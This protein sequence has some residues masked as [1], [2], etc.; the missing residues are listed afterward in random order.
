MPSTW[1]SHPIVTPLTL[2]LVN[3]VAPR[4]HPHTSR[5]YTSFSHTVKRHFAELWRQIY[6]GSLFFPM[7]TCVMQH[8][9][10]PSRRMWA[11]FFKHSLHM[12]PYLANFT[13]TC[14]A[15]TMLSLTSS[16]Y[17]DITLATDISCVHMASVMDFMSRGVN[18]GRI[19]TALFRINYPF[20]YSYSASGTYTWRYPFRK[21]R[22]VTFDSFT[23]IAYT[24]Y[25][26]FCLARNSQSQTNLPLTIRS[27]QLTTADC[28]F[29]PL[30]LL[31]WDS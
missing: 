18:W 9:R 5:C 1:L 7:H 19:P 8:L 4:S 25:L 29:F 27:F 10:L 23:L 22:R 21:S 31:T 3:P 6:L 17:A 12:S 24:S 20:W 30:L 28:W 13:M 11:P 14:F 26:R 15:D 2:L 16:I